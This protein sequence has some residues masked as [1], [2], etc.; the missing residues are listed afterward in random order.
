MDVGG[1]MAAPQGLQPSPAVEAVAP[2]HVER[3]NPVVQQQLHLES[4]KIRALSLYKVVSHILEDFDAF[5][6]SNSTIKW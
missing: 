4:V 6:R 1:A 3:L 2:P 5:A